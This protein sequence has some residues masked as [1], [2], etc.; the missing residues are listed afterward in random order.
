MNKIFKKIENSIHKDQPEIL[1][2]K[3]INRVQ[4]LNHECNEHIIKKTNVSYKSDI[5]M[6]IHLYTNTVLG[7]SVR[8]SVCVSVRAL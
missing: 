6:I 3:L 1:E 2:N 4:N 7:G 5:I 8:L